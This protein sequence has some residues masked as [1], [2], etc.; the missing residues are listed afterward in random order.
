M[1]SRK[2]EVSSDGIGTM[3]V[4]TIVFIVLKLVGTITWSW[5]WVL[6]PLWLP[7]TVVIS[8]GAI[9]YLIFFVAILGIEGFKKIKYKLTKQS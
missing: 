9:G 3:G 1:S 5:W 2:K 8:C 6:S 7:I 4:L